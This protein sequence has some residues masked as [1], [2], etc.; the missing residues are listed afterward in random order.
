[1][2]TGESDGYLKICYCRCFLVIMIFKDIN[3]NSTVYWSKRKDF[4][5][6]NLE[7]DIFETLTNKA[8]Q[9]DHNV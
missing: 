8:I 2:M 4:A 7:W 5:I 6:S 1:M 3:W 9:T